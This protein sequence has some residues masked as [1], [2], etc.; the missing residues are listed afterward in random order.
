MAGG[1]VI[2]APHAGSRAGTRLETVVAAVVAAALGVFLIWVV[3]F[4]AIPALHN[5]A[6]DTRHSISFPCH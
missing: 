6:H 4:S 2:A 1:I 3:G 5:A